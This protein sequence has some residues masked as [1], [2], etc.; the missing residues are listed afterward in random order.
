MGRH[1]SGLC[2]IL[3]LGER[4]EKKKERER[5]RKKKKKEKKRELYHTLKP[6][7]HKIRTNTCRNEDK[8]S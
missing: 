6:D 7:P 2:L 5:E 8:V 1:F 3:T 4:R